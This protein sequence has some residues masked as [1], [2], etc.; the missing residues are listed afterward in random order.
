MKLL[1]KLTL[2]FLLLLLSGLAMAADLKIAYASL[3]ISLDP[4][5]LVSGN[6]LRLSYLIFDPLVRYSKDM[7]P[8]GQLAKRWKRI[9][10][11]TMR[12]Y[13]R[14]GV[15]FHSGNKMTADDILWTFKRLKT[16]ADFKAVFNPFTTVNKIDDYTVDFVTAAPYPLVLQTMRYFFVMD[17]HFY[18]GKTVDGKDK[19]AIM[20]G[21]DSFASTHESGT[22]AFKVVSIEHGVKIKLKRFKQY[23]N[24]Q[25]QGN[26]DNITLVAIKENATRTAALLSGGVDIA[27]PISTHDQKRVRD[28]DGLDIIYTNTNR[29]ISFQLNEASNP[30]LKNKKVRQAIDYAVNN[31]GIVKKIMQGVATTAAQQSPKGF[32]GHNDQ[33]TPRYNVKKAKAL[34]KQAGYPQGFKLSLVAP[35]DRYVN[36]EKIAQATAIMLAKI[37]IKVD[38]K[39]LP[40]AQY[41]NEYFANCQG[42]MMLIGWEPDTMDS[43]NYTEF[44][45]M[46]RNAKTGRGQYNCGHYSNAKVDE[47]IETSNQETNPKKRAKMLQQAEAMI[48]DDAAFIPLH[49]QKLSWGVKQRVKNLGDI[50]DPQNFVFLSELRVAD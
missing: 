50:I 46:T 49:W 33:L 18:S 38:L 43:A 20:K 14:H 5:E 48:Y 27:Q 34:M 10:K 19:A 7:Q 44:L 16:S 15:T 8:E 6:Y 1:P 17:S 25:N 32:A 37:G 3:P 29:I 22:G 9:D 42:D 13:L 40:N 4:E 41:F 11:T 2:T 31:T 21:R 23:W 24:K 28:A 36:D 39:T 35:N 45:L 30:A 12:F 26:V 47:L